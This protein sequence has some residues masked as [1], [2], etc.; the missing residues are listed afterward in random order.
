RIRVP[1]E[2]VPRISKEYQEE[3]RR[4]TSESFFRQEFCCSF[5]ALEGLVYPDLE[6]CVV[7]AEPP[8]G[9]WYGGIDFGL[10]NPFAAVW[11]VL[12][13]DDVFWVTNEYYMRDKS[14]VFHAR[15]L[16]R[17]VTWYADPSG[18]QEIKELH[19]AGLAVRKAINKR[20]PGI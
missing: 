15:H 4:D 2:Q 18:A 5:E 3:V 10:R 11:G 12:D 17:H 14:L 13:R 20:R 6:E 8:E 9:R 16:P 1:V 7:Q 19:C